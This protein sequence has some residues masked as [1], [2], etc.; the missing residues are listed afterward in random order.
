MAR[1]AE[2][3]FDVRSAL[4]R[5][6]GAERAVT[7]ATRRGAYR[8]DKGRG[9]K[10]RYKSAVGMA[11]HAGSKHSRNLLAKS[12][13]E[14]SGLKDFRV[15]VCCNARATQEVI[16]LASGRVCAVALRT[17]P[18]GGDRTHLF[19]VYLRK[20]QESLAA[21]DH[22]EKRRGKGGV[23]KVAAMKRFSNVAVHEATSRAQM[24]NWRYSREI[25]P[26]G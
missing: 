4:G 26:W 10:G 2:G 16:K 19:A 21:N 13:P 6:T 9:S 15:D 20:R 12:R 7:E 24:Q 5:D 23:V 25:D 22:T 18:S 11:R 14:S 8:T 17:E 1:P 3:T